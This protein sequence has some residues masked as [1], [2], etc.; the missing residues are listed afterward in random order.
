VTTTSSADNSAAGEN[1]IPFNVP[2]TGTGPQAV[3]RTVARLRPRILAGDGAA[4]AQAIR[5]ARTWW[6]AYEAVCNASGEDAAAYLQEAWAAL[7]NAV[8]HAPAN[9]LAGVVAKARLADWL[10]RECSGEW[11]PWQGELARTLPAGDDDA[12]E[13]GEAEASRR[14]LKVAWLPREYRGLLRERGGRG[15]TVA[16]LLADLA[17]LLPERGAR[18]ERAR[19]LLRAAER[20]SAAAQ[21]AEEE[22]TDAAERA[23]GVRRVLETQE[24]ELRRLAGH[25]AAMTRGRAAARREATTK[26]RQALGLGE[27]AC[28]AEIRA[29]IARRRAV[30]VA[31]A[32]RVATSGSGSALPELDHAAGDLVSGAGDERRIG[33]AACVLEAAMRARVAQVKAAREIAATFGKRVIVPPKASP[34]AVTADTVKTWRERLRRTKSKGTRRDLW[35]RFGAW[36]REPDRKPCPAWLRV[37]LDRMRGRM[38]AAAAGARNI[39]APPKPAT[40]YEAALRALRRANGGGP[41]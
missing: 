22:A 8:A 29:E 3:Y 35:D 24:A 14:R 30:L 38:A 40:I 13:W 15:L 12:A 33:M 16:A 37:E 32:L 2:D 21:R 7:E 20:V 18:A 31:G 41:A 36:L 34:Q 4:M 17:A 23:R 5:H 26:A 27:D 10:M 6:D 25:E 9:D 11:A 19:R 1:I 28:V 39:E